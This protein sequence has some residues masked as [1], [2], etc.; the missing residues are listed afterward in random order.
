M[1]NVFSTNRITGGA[2]HYADFPLAKNSN[3]DLSSIVAL[4]N[5]NLYREIVPHDHFLRLRAIPEHSQG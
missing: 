1:D 2:A 5:L 3:S 4:L